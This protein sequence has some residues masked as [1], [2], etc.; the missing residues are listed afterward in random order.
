MD[1][2]LHSQSYFGRLLDKLGGWYVILAIIA[3]QVAA[4]IT[5]F[6]GLI[7]EQIN[8][9][10]TPQIVAL[11]IKISYI[12]VPITI[13]GLTLISFILSR[14]IRLQIQA[15]KSRPEL[16]SPEL[17]LKAW[18]DTH[19][20]TWRYALIA[21]FLISI[22]V[23]LPRSFILNILPL[24][25]RDQSIYSLIAGLITMLAFIPFSTAILDRLM[26]PVRKIL[27]PEDFE[28][29]LAGRGNLRLLYKNQAM[30]FISLLLTIF[31]IAPIGYHQTSKAISANINSQQVLVDY[32]LQ[33]IIMSLFAIIFASSLSFLVTRSTSN[34]LGQL[35]ETFQKVE[36]G[37]LSARTPV[38]SSDEG[39]ELAIYFNR[40]IS[41]LEELQSS[42]E[43]KVSERTSHL[44][45]INA[46]G[47]AATSI[48]DPD[49]LLNRVV[50]L[51]TEEFDFYYSAIY[52]LDSGGQWAELT[53]A[54]GEA[55]RVLKESKHRQP[56]D[57]TNI[58]GQSIRSREA[59]AAFDVGD[60]PTRFNNPLLPYTRS[61]I[62]LPLYVGN[63]ILGSLDVQSTQPSA[64]SEEDIETLQ[65][66]AN[67]VAISLDNARL[68]QETR[69]SLS[70]MHNIQKRYLREA[71]VESNLPQSSVSLAV[72]DQHETDE[73]DQII[74]PIALRDQKIGE[75]NLQGS[76]QLTP[77]ETN[78]VQAIVTQAALALENA[79]LLEESQ[80]SAM[81]EKFVTEIN[82]KIWSSTTIDGVLQTAVRELGQI[83]DATEAT[84]EIDAQ[85]E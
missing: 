46:V 42:L 68:F 82:S 61:E 52:Q 37:D 12:S 47:R 65:N 71:W 69:Q 31:L 41:R 51:I 74:L 8:A 80:A 55:G 14:N 7:F 78:W 39:G 38:I 26:I 6:L 16:A 81:R 44:Q 19:T 27:L 62:S 10:Y 18:R 3:T 54:T 67:Q 22:C 36:M 21:T 9:E 43:V 29:Q 53:E 25:S 58:I 79:R 76:G 50:N 30:I 45:A 66:M 60:N 49:E 2:S 4:S 13:I 23:V 70:E 5:I 32:Q 75:I 48:L 64:F 85:G 83:L 17:S 11:L 33:S 57:D 77:E 73:E 15:L 20:V 59:K 84:I 24:A 35:L 40:M 72:G 56:V 63:R 34:S 28:D 1:T